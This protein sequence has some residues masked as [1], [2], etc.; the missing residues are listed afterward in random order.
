MGLILP[1]VRKLF[2][3]DPGYTMFEA[4][5]V[6]ADAQIVAWEAED[7]DLKKAFREGLDVHVKNAEDMFGTSFT[8]L[9][10]HARD[11]KRQECKRTVHLTNYGGT[12][13]TIA[14]AIG[15]T[16]HEAD[17]FQRRWFSLH[18]GIKT[19]FQGRT[20]AELNRNRTIYNKYGYR[21]VYFGRMDSC[22]TEA[23][24]WKPQ[25][26]VALTTYYGA[27][28]LEAKY[29]QVEI[30][31]QDHDSLLFQVPNLKIP[32][33]SSIKKALEIITPYDDP[34]IIPWSLSSSTISWGDM[35]KIK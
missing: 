18:P 35:Q 30:L 14:I 21:R 26:S 22:Y 29:P 1:N 23:L 28:S 13:R 8:K 3:P 6:G 9:T 2:V 15:W 5:L 12:P 10:G 31:L 32:E 11:A 4:D 33:A 20:S 7:E 24:A 27:F 34:L 25:S 19:N 16:T 17:T